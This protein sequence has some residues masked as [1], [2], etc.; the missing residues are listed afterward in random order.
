MHVQP[1]LIHERH[2][3]K[4]EPF[5]WIATFEGLAILLLIAL[6]LIIF[7]AYWALL[8][9]GWA[10]TWLLV[11]A[12]GL[13]LLRISIKLLIK[14]VWENNHLS[15]YKLYEDRIEWVEFN[16]KARSK[17]EDTT[18]LGQVT[19]AYIGRY[20]AMHHYAYKKSKWREKQPLY[21]FLPSLHIVYRRGMGIETFEIPFYEPKDMEPW[22]A[23]LQGA[24]IPVQVYVALM[25]HKMDTEQRLTSLSKPGY[26]FPYD[27]ERPLAEAYHQ[28][29]I[30]MDEQAG[31]LTNPEKSLPS[32]AVST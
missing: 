16:K 13:W 1:K 31:K 19:E 21:H 6:A 15:T 3:R 18:P 23:A 28:L 9:Q 24:G 17:R 30:R 25:G 2:D 8:Y 32:T 27:E 22:L 5:Y 10:F 20:F 26:T 29:V 14:Y 12:L 7:P 11:S 4:M